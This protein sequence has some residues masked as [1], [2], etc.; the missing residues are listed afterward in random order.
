MVLLFFIFLWGFFYRRRTG[1][2][3]AKREI[4]KTRTKTK[5][6]EFLFQT[7]KNHPKSC[8][9]CV[10]FFTSFAVFIDF[11]A[12]FIKEFEKRTSLTS[13]GVF[14]MRSQILSELLVVC[15][16]PH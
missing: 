11:F 10:L 7:K 9:V 6:R 16:L 2:F 14:N 13:K 12:L 8:E 5:K 1:I 3:R 15:E 4:Q